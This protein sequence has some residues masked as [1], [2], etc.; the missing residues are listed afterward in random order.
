MGGRA[1]TGTAYRA[2]T[3]TYPRGPARRC[4]R[5]ELLMR[6]LIREP[7]LGL[8]LLVLVG[9]MASEANHTFLTRLLF[10]R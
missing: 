3:R 1:T 7:A 5:H 4:A 2:P 10:F 8:T 6:L 9:L